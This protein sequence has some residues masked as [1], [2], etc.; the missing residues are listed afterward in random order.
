MGLG[1]FFHTSQ[2]G[3]RKL[4]SIKDKMGLGSFFVTEKMAL[5]WLFCKSRMALGRFCENGLFV[6]TALEARMALGRFWRNLLFVLAVL[7]SR[8][9][10]G[11]FFLTAR[12]GLGWLFLSPFDLY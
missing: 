7:E 5:G 4:F 6:L 11:R 10:L 9:A 3:S 12:M 1:W 8:M 2:N